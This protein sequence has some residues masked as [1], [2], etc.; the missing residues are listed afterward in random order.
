MQNI[1]I[2]G[3]IEYT[4]NYVN[5]LLYAGKKPRVSL[6]P[7]DVYWCDGLILPGGGDISPAFWGEEKGD[8]E[9]VCSALDSAQAVMLQ[10]AVQA[11]IPVF[12]ICKGH[13]LIQVYFGG[14]V[15]GNISSAKTHTGKNG[16]DAL[17]RIETVPGSLLEAIYGRRLTVNSWHHQAVGQVASGFSVSAFWKGEQETIIEALEHTRLPIFSVQWHPERMS[18]GRHRRDTADGAALFEAFFAENYYKSPVSEQGR[19]GCLQT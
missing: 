19:A 17:H 7:Q 9:A 18:Y 13:Q 16:Q 3:E 11:E 14:T 5:A 6:Q 4:V 12:G 1:V 15:I 2:A 10:C 8:S